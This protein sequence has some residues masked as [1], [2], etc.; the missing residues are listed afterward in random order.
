MSAISGFSRF[1]LNPQILRALEELGFEEPTPIQEKILP[2]ASGGQD[3]MGIAQTGTGKTGAFAIP[4]LMKLRYAQGN[5]PR[6]LILAPTKELVIQIKQHTEALAVNMDIRLIALYGGVGP[7]QQIEEIQNGVDLI[8]ATPGRLLDVYH[9]INFVV[10]EIKTLIIDEADRMMDMGFMPQ[11]RKVL[12]ILPQKKQKLLFSATMP[13]KVVQ[14]SEEFLDH[15]QI[16]EITP[17]ATTAQTI[18]QCIYL[19]PNLKTKIYFLEKLLSSPEFERVIVFVNTK[20]RADTVFKFIERKVEGGV[21]VIHSNKGQN[22]RINAVNLFSSG[23]LRT[24][25]ATNVAARGLDIDHVTHV[26]NFDVPTKYEEYVHRVGRTGRAQLAGQAITFVNKAEEYHIVKIEE[27]I[28]EKIERRTL[29]GN[30]ILFETPKWESQ[31]M[32]RE[33]DNQRKKEDPTFQG[34]FHDK[35]KKSKSDFDKKL[36]RKK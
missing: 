6:A 15:P 5:N 29:P 27:L 35:K 24:L 16:V 18:S 34:A 9:R 13:P 36:G 3:I 23:E 33:I 21:R 14:L 31:L 28:K 8:I 22:S 19:T 2:I 30:V 20:E 25:V 26:I 12:E 1:K 32:A 11:I 17:S 10:K 4:L 7:K